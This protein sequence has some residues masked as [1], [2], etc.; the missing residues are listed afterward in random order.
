L[1]SGERLTE[2]IYTEV[3][4]KV[5]VSKVTRHRDS[6]YEML[7]ILGV[8][9]SGYHA[10]LNQKVYSSNQHKEAVKKKI[11]NIYDSSK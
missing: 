7:I 9:R 2:S 11:Q 10:F 5:E 8:S 4:A 6:T 3:S 1:H